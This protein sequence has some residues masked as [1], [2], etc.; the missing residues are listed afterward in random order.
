MNALVIV[1]WLLVIVLLVVIS[2][3]EIQTARAN[4]TSSVVDGNI[5]SWYY[6]YHG[7]GWVSW[8]RPWV[9]AGVIIQALGITAIYTHELWLAMLCLIT[10]AVVICVKICGKWTKDRSQLFRKIVEVVI[11]FLFLGWFAVVFGSVIPR[12]HTTQ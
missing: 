10:Q 6:W 7:T 9:M 12:L 1:S 2:T 4:H 5:G 11:R 8:L 3:F